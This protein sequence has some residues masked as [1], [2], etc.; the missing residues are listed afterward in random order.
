LT[1][2]E[3]GKAGQAVSD[4]AVL[5]IAAANQRAMLTLNRRHFI[6]LHSTQPGHAGIIVCSFDPDFIALAERIHAAIGLQEQLSSS[7]IR[8]NQP[9]S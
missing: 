2:Q 3:T 8:I 9:S 4:E 6:G 5:T 1:L 7:L